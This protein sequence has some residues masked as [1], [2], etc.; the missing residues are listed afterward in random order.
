MLLESKT[1]FKPSQIKELLDDFKFVKNNKGLEY[2]NVPISF[3]I[4]TTSFYNALGEKQAIMYAWVFG[5]NGK[6]IIGRTWDEFL[7][8]LDVIKKHYQLESNKR[9]I[10]WIHNLAFEF[11]FIQHLFEWDNVFAVDD[12]KPVYAVCGG[13]E[14]RCSYILSGYSLAMVAKNLTQYKIEKLVGD[15]DYSKL[16]HSLTPLTDL[17]Y[18]YILNDGLIVM[19]YIQEL[20]NQ[21]GDFHKLPLTQTG[22]VRKYVRTE[23]LYGGNAS[24]KKSGTAYAYKKYHNLMSVLTIPSYPVYKQMKRV[25]TGGFTHCNALYSGITIDDVTSYDFTS[26]YPAVMIMEKYPMSKP[27]TIQLKSTEEFYNYLKTHCCMFDIKF[28]NIKPKLYQD[29]P[30]SASKCC[31]MVNQIEDN[32][33]IVSADELVTS[34]NEVDFKILSEFYQWDYIDV[35]NFRIMLKGYLPTPFVKAILKLY[36]LKTTLK[37]STDLDDLIR[38]MNSKQN[39]NGCYGMAVTDILQMNRLYKN[40]EWLT[41]E[42]DIQKVFEKYNTSKSRFLYY[43]WG[44]WVTSYARRNLFLGIQAVGRDYIY[45]DTDSIKIRN[46]EKHK[47]WINKYNE[48]VRFKLEK[49]MSFHK[50]PFEM[51]EPQTRKGSKKLIG[52]WDFDGYYYHFKTLGAKRYMYEDEN[53]FHLTCS[54]ASK[55]AIFYLC[56]GMYC[57]IKSH[58]P[59]FDV[60]E[61]F[62]NNLQIPASKTGKNIHTY[63]DNEM[64]GYITDYLGNTSSYHELSGVHL[65]PAEYNLS[66]SKNYL[67]Y[68]SGVQQLH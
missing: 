13:I 46:G 33:R 16:R 56:D 36:E 26:S 54:G 14:F 49:A 62:A 25:Y 63:I 45:A 21:Y 19:A 67:T 42:P 48:W 41:E 37:G 57:D 58:K 61:K 65:E 24:H 50:L 15:L 34:I 17:E 43:P 60:F 22:F 52:V 31:L 47:A 35:W 27:Q 59:N 40:G 32:G 44:I 4:E 53:G 1:I 38:Y 9:I 12:R 3:D 51:C 66:L 55:K 2:M 6:C 28:Y 39:L 68:L 20:L 5:I 64:S 8:I 30:L 18:Q 23:C 29:H 11:V 7:L 10:C